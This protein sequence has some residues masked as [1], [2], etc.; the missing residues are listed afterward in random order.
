M[1]KIQANMCFDMVFLSK[2]IRTCLLT[3]FP[4]FSPFSAHFT[5]PLHH[6]RK[7]SIVP[8]VHSRQNGLE[9]DYIPHCAGLVINHNHICNY[10]LY[11]G[12]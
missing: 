4:V 7:R 2:N 8:I 12:Q 10:H 1:E 3:R 5:P 6:N 11:S 9:P